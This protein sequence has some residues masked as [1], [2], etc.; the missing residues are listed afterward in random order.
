MTITNNTVS[1]NYATM[2]DL[3]S[4]EEHIKQTLRNYLERTG[5]DKEI[6]DS[7]VTIGKNNYT[8]NILLG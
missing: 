2:E 7:F 5:S 4:R 1:I 8:L 3:L 6:K